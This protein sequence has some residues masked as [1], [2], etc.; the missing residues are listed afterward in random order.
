MSQGRRLKINRAA[1]F[2]AKGDLDLGPTLLAAVRL[3]TT[4]SHHCTFADG[5]GMAPRMTHASAAQICFVEE[6]P[7]RA[8]EGGAA[9]VVR[10]HVAR[11]RHR[12]RR[13]ADVRAFRE[14]KVEV[15]EDVRSRGREEEEDEVE[16]LAVQEIPALAENRLVQA[17]IQPSIL[18]Q[19]N[20][21]W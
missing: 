20:C 9:S 2:L 13:D 4:T 18:Y 10:S 6:A 21:E 8:R 1:P 19:D 14:S 16:D 12:R 5:H 7:G 11:L 3:R 17:T 15:V